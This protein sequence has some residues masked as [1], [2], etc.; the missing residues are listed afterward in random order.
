MGSAGRCAG[1]ILFAT[2]I[3]MAL[4]GTGTGR[5]PWRYRDYV[6]KAFNEDKPYDRF[7]R[8][9]LAGDELWP[10]NQE[11]LIASGF[12]RLGPVHIVGGVQDEEMNRQERLTEM[13]GVVGPVFLGMTVG[14]AR[15]HNHKFDPILQSDYYRLQAIFAGTEFKDWVIAAETEKAACEAAKKAF[16]ARL[17]PIKEEI[18][19]LEKPTRE[20]LRARK[21]AMLEAALRDVLAVSKDERTE[22]Q[23]KLAKDAESQVEVRWDELFEALPA[24]VRERRAGLRAQLGRLQATEPE[25]VPAAFAVTDMEGTPPPTHILQVG[26]YKHKLG[27]VQPGFLKVLVPDYG[28]VPQTA[29]GRRAALANWLASPDHPLTARVMVNRIWQFRMGT[30]I[31]GTPNDFGALGQRPTN[32]SLLDWLATE[33]VQNKWSVKSLDRLIVLSNDYRQSSA[34][35]AAKAKIDPENKLYWRMNRRRLEGETIRDN[36]L[37]VAGTLN[38]K[39]GGKPVLVPIRRKYTT[40]YLRR[41]SREDNSVAND[42]GSSRAYPKELV[43]SQQARRPPSPVC[44][45]RPTGHDDFVSNAPDQYPRAPEPDVIQ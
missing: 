32:Q 10:D 31:V 19:A 15:C 21:V 4:K 16:D 41:G 25:P 44:Q 9:Q 12:N 37:A 26:D 2:P 23:K 28:A 33:F 8:E 24:D 42:L 18:A 13:A 45:L 36:V 40:L 3:R 27:M 38:D 11:A 39:I 30:G 35:E 34:S 17:K 22:E 20:Q 14:C 5:T 6:V 29:A 7:I 43:S 1:L